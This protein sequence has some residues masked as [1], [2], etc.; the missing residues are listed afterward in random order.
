MSRV[1][2]VKDGKVV[3]DMDTDAYLRNDKTTEELVKDQYESNM[4]KELKF[5]EDW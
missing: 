3:V 4:K 5:G 1:K 2:I